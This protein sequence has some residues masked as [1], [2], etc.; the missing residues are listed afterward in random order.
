MLDKNIISE[1]IL[2]KLLIE[3]NT[4]QKLIEQLNEG[5]SHAVNLIYHNHGRLIVTGIGK[6]ALIAMKIAAES[7]RPQVE[8]NTSIEQVLNQIT[9]R[10]FGTTGVKVKKK[11]KGYVTDGDIRRMS[12]QKSD[13]HKLMSRDIMSPNPFNIEGNVLSVE[14]FR[15]F[16]EKSINPKIV[17][18]TKGQF[19]R[20]VHD[21]D[22][23]KQG[24]SE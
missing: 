11:I 4:V 12:N 1:D 20:I 7:H 14:A 9:I 6:S 3:A 10:R 13:I 8:F 22:L 24:I 18:D 5:F 16:E 23:I 21:L 19:K 17:V 15:I 2:A